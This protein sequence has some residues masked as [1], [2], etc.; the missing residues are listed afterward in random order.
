MNIAIIGGSITEGAGASEYNKSYVYR[1]EE[2]LKKGYKNIVIK[3]L[4]VGGTGSQFGIFRLKRDLAGFTPD[5]VFI[6]FSVNDR[7]LNSSDISIYFEG[8]IREC[9]KITSKIIVLGFPTGMADSCTSIH[10]KFAYFYDI[11]FIDV[12]DEVFKRIGKKEITWTQI[13]IDNLHPNDK[14]HELY[15]DIIRD[16]LKNIN[17]E[18]IKLNIDK[19]VLSKYRFINPKIEAYDSTNIEYYGQ[20]KE[21]KFNLNNKFNYGAVTENIGDGIIFEFKG[22]SLGMMN[23]MTKNSGILECK[24]DNYEF[25]IDLYINSE[26]H[27]ATTI[28]LNGLKDDNHTL[29][30]NVSNNKNRDSIGNK[31]IIGGFLVDYLE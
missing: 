18:D 20:W 8:L 14:G 19:K 31:I 3:N 27:F 13:S 26:N 22:K 4:G 2:Y 23:I 12:Q 5:V 7:I 1:L 15:F 24:L 28:N 6:E 11:P 25:Y 21:E 17:L 29:I 9:A 16:R 10:K 30:M